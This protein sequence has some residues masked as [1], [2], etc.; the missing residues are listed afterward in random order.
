MAM[1][2]HDPEDWQRASPFAIVFF[3]GS[4]FKVFRQILIQGGLPVVVLVIAFWDNLGRMDVLLFL[5]AV[6]ILMVLAGAAIQWACFRFRIGEDRLLIRK[7]F[8]KKT[9]VDLPYERTLGVNVQRSLV[10]RVIGLVTVTL[11][12][13]GSTQA[14]GRLPSI[15]TEVANRLRARVAAALPTNAGADAAL[16]ASDAADGRL[17]APSR[18]GRILIK[19]GPADMVRIGLGSRNFLFAAAM[20][21]ILS[22]LLQPGNP[23]EAVR[24]AVATGVD[25]ATSAVSG[26]G[27]FAQTALATMLILAVLTTALVLTVTA[28]FL[29]HY[30]FALWHDGSTFRSRSGLFTQREVV[31]ETP[32][33]QQLTVSQDIVMRWFKRFRLRAL[34][35]A[36]NAAQG[37]AASGDLDLAGALDI[38]LLSDRAVEDL[39]ARVFGREAQSIAALPHSTAFRRVSP[40]Y[41]RTLTLRIWVIAG[42]VLGFISLA[43]LP[44]GGFPNAWM[45]FGWIAFLPV[46]AGVAW[47]VWRRRGYACDKDGVATRS[48]FLGSKTNAFLMRKAQSATLKQSP[49]Q[50]RKGLAT[51]QVQLACGS[52][53]VP[54]IDEGAARRLRDYILYKVETS[55]R[56]WH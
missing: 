45:L 14:E 7:G 53:T 5:G 40:Y 11:D 2:P 28:A 15:R 31:V 46:A 26:L 39:H 43:L 19:L 41:I 23:V 13:S 47:Q 16:D 49:F 22:D 35:A 51:L 50:R 12:T 37:G 56:R 42:L 36:A 27:A 20:I 24:E 10:D 33:I 52:V 48:G 1:N 30:A 55:Q 4:A 3:V 32:K 8:V 18:R 25:N 44:S 29:R 38:P 6:A 17:A 9:R 54:Y 21:G 34:P